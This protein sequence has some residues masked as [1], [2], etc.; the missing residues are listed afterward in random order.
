MIKDDELIRMLAILN[1]NNV[2]EI[3]LTLLKETKN[4]QIYE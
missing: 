4:F 2:T 3:K 1:H